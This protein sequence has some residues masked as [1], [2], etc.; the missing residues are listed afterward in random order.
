MSIIANLKPNVFNANVHVYITTH[1]TVQT[2]V[3]LY[4]NQILKIKIGSKLLGIAT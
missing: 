4:V 1:Y 2:I 3:I